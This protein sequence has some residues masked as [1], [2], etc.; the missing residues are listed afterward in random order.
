M[1]TSS[2]ENNIK[3]S[4]KILVVDDLP[5][6][7]RML[8][9]ALN[10]MGYKNIV[11]VENGAEAINELERYSRVS[12]D[13]YSLML[14][15]LNMPEKSGLDVL[16]FVR[17]NDTIKKLPIIV[18]TAENSKEVVLQTMYYGAE[19]Y[20]IKPISQ[21]KVMEKVEKVLGYSGKLIG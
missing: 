18:I 6:M 12:T 7:R 20:M 19:E 13:G 2:H 10:N 1:T 11:E 14:L 3:K 9:I 17:A 21:K 15:D 4:V 8:R 16:K 5:V